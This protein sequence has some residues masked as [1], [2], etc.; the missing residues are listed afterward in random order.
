V[1]K[2]TTH[3]IGYVGKNASRGRGG[4]GRST[5]LW[6][7]RENGKKGQKGSQLHKK[8]P[9]L[10]KTVNLGTI[11]EPEGEEKRQRME[12]TISS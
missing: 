6:G 4:K 11:E 10:S 2:K 8:S 1:K 3:F 12:N 5:W 9:L 7:R